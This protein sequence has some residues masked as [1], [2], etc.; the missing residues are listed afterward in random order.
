MISGYNRNW[1][2]WFR[3]M[4]IAKLNCGNYCV[5]HK[6]STPLPCQFP[7]KRI[8]PPSTLYA[9][10]CL[11]QHI[12]THGGEIMYCECFDFRGEL[13]I[14]N[15]D[16]I[17]MCVVNKQFQLLKFVFDSVYINLHYD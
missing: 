12:G 2:L 9:V 17:C 10:S 5:V 3:P 15:C 14:L 16:D 7:Y 11:V 6:Q 8:E 4:F 1:V 13:G